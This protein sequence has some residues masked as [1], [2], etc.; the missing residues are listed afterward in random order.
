MM[1]G[2]VVGPFFIIGNLNAEVYLAM[3]QQQVV[4]AIQASVNNFE[5]IWFQQD[6]APPHYGLEVRQ[7]LDI[8]FPNHWIGRRGYI[9]WPARSS[10]LSPLDY[11]LWG[12]VKDRVYKTKPQNLDDIRN[13]IQQEIQQIPQDTLQRVV[14]HFYITL[15]HCSNR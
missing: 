11:F 6:G 1:G 4:P 15:A 8:V 5:Q 3:L 10:D 7:Y 2:Q 13:R 12:H 14:S 9:E